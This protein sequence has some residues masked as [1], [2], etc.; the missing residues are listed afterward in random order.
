MF[1]R[2]PGLACIRSGKHVL[3]EKPLAHTVTGCKRLVRAADE[4]GVCLATG[5]NLRFTRTAILARRLVDEGEIGSVSH[6]RAFC[7]AAPDKS[8]L[9]G[10][11]S[12]PSRSGGGAAMDCGVHVIDL[13]RWFLGDLTPLASVGTNRVLKDAYCEDN[14]VL[15][16]CDVQGRTAGLHA[17]WT[18]WRGHRYEI[19]VAGSEGFVRWSYPPLHLVHGR[20]RPD[21]SVRV[22]HHWFPSYQ[23]A[24]RLWGW[25]WGVVDSLA[26]ELSAWADAIR[27]G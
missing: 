11:R 19:E 3:C 27:K 24:E 4:A 2:G 5:F 10:W 6:V 1:A 20:R 16:L 18:H 14:G 22:R 17:T 8:I 7:G 21:G 12:D 13:A 23:L 9:D 25:Q 26:R 15:L